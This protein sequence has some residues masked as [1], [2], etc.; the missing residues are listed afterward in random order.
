MYFS[1]TDELDEYMAILSDINA[2]LSKMGAAQFQE[3]GD[4]L[5]H[6]IYRPINIESRGSK[7]GQVKTRK[8]S[9]DTIF[10]IPTGKVLIEYTTQS[11]RPQS[12]FIRKLKNDITSCLDVKKTKIPLAEIVEIVLF[13]NQRIATDIQDD[14]RASLLSQYPYIKLTIFAIDDVAIKLRGYPVL[15][16]TYLG[17]SSFPGLVEIDSFIKRFS[18]K[19]FSYLTPLDNT[20][21]EFETLPI[22][23]GLEIL[24]TTDIIIIS[25]EPGMGKTRYAVEIAKAYSIKTGANVFVIEEKNRSVREILDYIDKNTCY[26]FIIDDANRTAIWDEAIEFYETS[27]SNNVKFIATVRSY[28]RDSVLDKCSKC[29]NS[30]EIVMSETPEELASNILTSFGITNPIWHKRINDITSRNIRL[31]VMCAQIAMAGEKYNELLNVEGL[32]T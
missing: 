8:G 28:A 29:L 1:T 6:A 32:S 26:I 7:E 19:K 11:N 16:Q 23:K 15:L 17:I 5:L 2:E 12:S 10:T 25:G 27:S 9:P 24:K 31:A 4:E 3:L 22:S 20:F 14:L 18:C 30:E 21:F 13:S